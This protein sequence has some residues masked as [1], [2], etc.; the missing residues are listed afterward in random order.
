MRR[1]PNLAYNVLIVFSWKK[2][3]DYNLSDVISVSV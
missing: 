2:I 1:D 3:Y